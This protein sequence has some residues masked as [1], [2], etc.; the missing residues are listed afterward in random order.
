MSDISGEPLATNRSI[1]RSWQFW[2]GLVVSL[3]CL[4]LA[5]R[6]VDLSQVA[7]TLTRIKWLVAGIGGVECVGYVSNEGFA[8]ANVVCGW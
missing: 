8:L 5:L 6:G 1:L 2:L 7:S 4:V 3:G